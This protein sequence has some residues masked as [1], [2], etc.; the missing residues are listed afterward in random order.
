MLKPCARPDCDVRFTPHNNRQIYCC[1]PCQR[2]HEQDRLDRSGIR[3]ERPGRVPAKA[4]KLPRN[5]PGW[6]APCGPDE[7]LP[8]RSHSCTDHD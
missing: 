6:L 5:L 3:A 8:T 1:R 2:Q 7:C 4:F